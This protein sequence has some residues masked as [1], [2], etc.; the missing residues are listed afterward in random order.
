MSGVGGPLEKDTCRDYVLPRL[1]SSGWQDGMVRAEVPVVAEHGISVGGRT[2]IARDGRADYV[3]EIVPGLP[4]AVVEAKRLYAKPADGLQ[5]G[6]EYAAR[7]DVPLVYATNGDGIRERDL[8]SGQERTLESFPTPAEMWDRYVD[9]GRLTP[10]MQQ[11]VRQPFNRSLVDADGTTREPRAYQ[12]T[13][14]HRV[15]KAIA[16]GQQRVLLLMATGTGKTFTALQIVSKLLSYWSFAEPDRNRRVLYLADRDALVEQPIRSTFREALPAGSVT[17]VKR[18]AVMGHDVYFATYQ[19]LDQGQDPDSEAATLFEAYPADF[20]DLVIVDECHRGSAARDSSWRRILDHFSPA[21]QLG[22]TATPKQQD[23]IDTYGYFGEPVF[24]YSLREGIEDGYLAPYRVRRVWLSTDVDGWRPDP[25]QLDRFGR[26]IPDDLYSTPDFER[27][28]ALLA[29]T[30]AAAAHLSALLTQPNARAIVFCVDQEHAQQMRDALVEQNPARVAKDPWWAVRI[31]GADGETGRRLLDE[32]T[33]PESSSPVV[34]TTSRMLSTGVDVQD[35]THVVLFRPVGSMVEFKQIIGR[36]SRLYPEKGKTSFEIVD[37]VGATQLFQDP[38]FD[39]PA[40][41]VRVEHV[42]ADGSLLDVDEDVSPGTAE[43]V[44]SESLEL[45]EPEPEYVAGGSGTVE[46]V[47][48][49]PER[50]LPRKFLVDGVEVSLVAEGYQVPDTATG[51]L[52]LVEY[53]D[54]VGDRV[55]RLTDDAED[56]RQRWAR[57]DQRERIE[58]ALAAEGVEIH[59]LEERTGLSGADAFDVLVHAAWQLTPLTR[60]QRAQRVRA[61]LDV[62]PPLDVRAREVLDA[63]L[64]RYAEHGVDEMS[65]P[66]AL[67]LPPLAPLGSEVEIVSRFGGASGY[68]RAVADLQRTLYSA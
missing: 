9:V 35:L 36:G 39:G 67:T 14:V 60:A 63:L 24:E 59:E 11:V 66:L 25:G 1:G 2:R 43:S 7:L 4:V 3:L 5:Q 51:R 55:R 22:L 64:E 23:E 54:Y 27:V 31:T 65:D 19:A 48:P 32:L 12:R 15:L 52:R 41:R 53:A 40:Q 28:V 62:G 34:V 47:G 21:V 68:R 8:A 30:A 17:R 58:E 33:D 61:G 56:L 6:I 10:R 46:S 37:Y 49:A 26:E 44:G 38:S 13:A 57:K 20:F 29:R 18:R 16:G 50:P 45:A 42:D